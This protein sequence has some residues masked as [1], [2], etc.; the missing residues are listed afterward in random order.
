MLSG[1]KSLVH[2]QGY[3]QQR[4]FI[5]AQ[6]PMQ[7]TARDFWKVIYDKKCGVIVMLCN[8]MEDG[9]V[10]SVC[11]CVHAYVYLPVCVCVCMFLCADGCALH[12]CV[13]VCVCVCV[14]VYVCII[15][16]IVY[17]M[18]CRRYAI[19]TGQAVALRLLESSKL[20]YWNKKNRLAFSFTS[21][22]STIRRFN[23]TH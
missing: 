3:K 23:C 21:L 11:A 2:A 14:C 7:S 8:L 9:K 20:S 19:S 16:L 22:L 17:L 12:V 4:A 6:S 10:T 1:T 18:Y 13:H 15:W 5:I